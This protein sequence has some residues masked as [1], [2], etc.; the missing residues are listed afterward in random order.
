MRNS[1]E[2]KKEHGQ[3]DKY[4]KEGYTE[5]MLRMKMKEIKMIS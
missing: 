1:K 3:A 4:L 2:K 5:K